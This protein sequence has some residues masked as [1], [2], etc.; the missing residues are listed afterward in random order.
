MGHTLDQEPRIVPTPHATFE[1]IG[2][3]ATLTFN[4]PE[5]RNAMTWEMYQA[6]FDACEA[7][8]AS[9][10]I[11]TL[12]LKGAGG[13][14]FVSGTDIAQF[15]EFDS[16]GDGIAYERRLDE[17]MDRL[18]RVAKPTIAQIEGV[19]TGG[20]CAIALACD[21]RYCTPESR[22][23]MPIARTLGNCLS[24]ANH[25]RLVDLV[26]PARVKELI[27]TG[28]LI[29][30]AEA[31]SLG[32]VNRVIDGSRLGQSVRETAAAIAENAPLTIMATK[33]IVRRI[34]ASRRLDP[35]G[36]RDLIEL[37]Y[38]SEDFA[39]GVAAFLAKR[40]PKWKGK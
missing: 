21:L 26:G 2:P 3:L 32:L 10:E 24:A 20:G 12:I 23:G 13:E 9:E 29:D 16:P 17:V 19:A 34:Q 8:D 28:R 27:F 4:R 15:Q 6:L 11:R 31:A 14:A 35:D 7:V 25:A 22:F 38:T 37:C 30:A 33:E 18:E 39:E 1:T 36:A 5:V 40:P